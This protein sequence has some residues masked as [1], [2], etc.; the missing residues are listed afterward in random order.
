MMSKQNAQTRAAAAAKVAAEAKRRERRN[1]TLKIAAVVAAMAVIVVVGVIAGTHRGTN[2]KV[3]TSAASNA[4]AATYSLAVGDKSA[5]HTIVFYE[6]FLC[7]YCGMTERASEAGLDA[8]AKAGKVYIEYRPFNLLSSDPYSAQ[9]LNAF[10]AVRDIA[11]DDVALQFHNLLYENQP[12]EPGPKDGRDD[13]IK[14]ADQVVPAPDQ[15]KVADAIKNDSYASY[16]KGATA[17]A[18]KAGV[19]G[20]PT[21]LLDGENYQDGNNWAD[22]GQNLVKAVS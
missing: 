11:G 4:S 13:L 19:S 6:D 9:A 2:G 20:T 7:P 1:T 5:P 18:E 14:L 3:D 12:A 21:I 8:A 17:A 15:A 10:A 16:V 22:I